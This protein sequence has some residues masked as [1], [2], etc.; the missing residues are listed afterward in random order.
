[1]NFFDKDGKPLELMEWAEKFEDDE[2][3]QVD[4]T[5]LTNDRHVSTIWIG[6]NMNM[7]G[8][9]PII[10]ETAIFK[11]GRFVEVFGRCDTLENAMRMHKQAEQV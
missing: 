10:F 7:L 9:I 6:H 2:Y 1:M 3:R 11:K 4:W 8:N 5:E